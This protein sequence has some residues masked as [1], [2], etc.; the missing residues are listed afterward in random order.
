MRITETPNS[1]QV[2][3]VCGLSHADCKEQVP[4]LDPRILEA[5]WLWHLSY[6]FQVLQCELLKEI[7]FSNGSQTKLYFNSFL[8]CMLIGKNH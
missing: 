4:Y 6:D 7:S 5:E 3:G 1:M 2:F 8:G